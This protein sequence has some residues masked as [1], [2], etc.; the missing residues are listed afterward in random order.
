LFPTIVSRPSQFAVVDYSTLFAALNAD[1][2]AVVVPS[3]AWF[4]G[5]QPAAA[6]ARLARPPFRV[7]R[8][9]AARALER[10]FLDDPLAAGT[11]GVLF[12]AGLAAAALGLLGLVLAARS[13]LQAERLVTAEYEALGVDPPTLSRAA[14]LRLVLLSAVGVA[15]A[16]LGALL[17]VRIIASFVA[18]TGTATQPLPPIVGRVA[19]ADG[20]A[21]VGAVAVV[22]LGAVW[23]L[24]G[25]AFREST[26]A[27][28]RG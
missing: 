21:V 19:W 27:R 5:P 26:A 14:Q 24:I 16:G 9:I 8:L 13:A 7:E 25:R 28:L 4:F 10:H 18:V 3:E 22:G 11:R 2:P 23:V 12:I 6:A 20:A 1:E 17:A 15:A